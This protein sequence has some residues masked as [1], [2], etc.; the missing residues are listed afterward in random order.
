VTTVNFGDESE[1]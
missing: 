1:T